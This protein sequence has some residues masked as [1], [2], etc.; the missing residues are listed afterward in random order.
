MKIRRTEKE[1]GKQVEIRAV[2]KVLSERPAHPDAICN[3]LGKVWSPIRGVECKELGDNVFLF[4]FNQ[5]RERRKALDDGL[6]MFDN[7]LI[8][9]EEFVPRKRIEDYEFKEIPV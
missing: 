4:T 3:S 2:G 1:K 7:D 6:W 9:M 8:V 5:E